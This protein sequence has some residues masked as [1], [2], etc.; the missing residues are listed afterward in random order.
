MEPISVFFSYAREDLPFAKVAAELLRASGLRVFLDLDT[1]E[2]GTDWR[3]QVERAIRR[4]DRV[5]LIWSYEASRS[6]WVLM[7]AR[8][9]SRLK[10]IVV[11]VNLDD[12]SLPIRLRHV[13]AVAELGSI[14]RMYADASSV[15]AQ[16][17][18]QSDAQEA[19]AT[20]RD[21]EP[22]GRGRESIQP[23]LARIRKPRVHISYEVGLSRT[24]S[25]ADVSA[26]SRAVIEV[27]LPAP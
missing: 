13:H 26:F 9:A 3:V 24:F 20:E 14:L 2:Y 10:K 4:A 25:P 18:S 12:S 22:G 21:V 5:L 27:Q 15:T 7:E 17:R 23:K 19:M 6:R 11:P 1:L 16:C 8:L